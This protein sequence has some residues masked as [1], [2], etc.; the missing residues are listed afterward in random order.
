MKNLF[1]LIAGV[2]LISSCSSK[3][4]I[5]KRRYNHGLFV[6]VSGQSK[7][8]DHKPQQSE[9]RVAAK[10][11]VKADQQDIPRTVAQKP[12]AEPATEQVMIP[13][14]KVAKATATAKK[15]QTS[16]DGVIASASPVTAA[17]L[18]IR[19]LDDNTVAP[20]G[21]AKG[22]AK[23]D[24]DV[25]L[26]LLIILAIFIPPLAVFLKNGVDK[27]FW[28][29]LILFLLAFSFLFFKL[30]GLA[31]LAAVIIALLVVLDKL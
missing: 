6:S 5:M 31:G 29:T 9:R 11:A 2:M 10:P 14:V 17:P 15:P 16:N 20:K 22:H 28:I 30:G 25:N 26:I 18:E 19:T 7:H 1:L 3:F 12:A 8:N 4:T 23:G 24:S 13:A 21:K 27:W